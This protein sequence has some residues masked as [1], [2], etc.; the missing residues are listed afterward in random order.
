MIYA[1]PVS[2]YCWFRE[3]QSLLLLPYPPGL[4]GK[5]AGLIHI[6]CSCQHDGSRGKGGGRP[7][8]SSEHHLREEGPSDG[9]GFGGKL[10][11]LEWVEEGRI[12]G[13]FVIPLP[14]LEELE[15]TLR[16]EEEADER[17]YL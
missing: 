5:G 13:N 8:Y 14:R 7:R 9:Q 10:G 3:E 2:P 1:K 16:R 17:M 12:S 15:E 6:L 4:K 11:N